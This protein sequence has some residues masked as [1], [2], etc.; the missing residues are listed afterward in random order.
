V[1]VLLVEDDDRVAGALSVA[2]GRHQMDVDRTGT[3]QQALEHLGTGNNHDV[4]LLDL[5]LPDLDGQVLCRQIREISDI[6]LIVV[7][8]RAGMNARLRSLDLGADDY[9]L[10]P[11][12][13]RELVARIHAVTRRAGSPTAAAASATSALGVAV[14]V[15]RRE[16]VV[17]GSAVA[18][19]RK[20][21]NLL[22]VLARQPGIV[23]TRAR[24][25]AEVWDTAW[26][27]NQRTLEVHV[28]S[29]RAKV[30]VPGI[31]ETVRGVGYRFPPA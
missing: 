30:G 24:I 27:G 14:D 5:G 15:E 28:A 9:V 20:E 26:T 1:R 3:A 29:V 8:A 19:T 11:F 21:F 17:G 18:L 13:P 25:L 2:L 31:I 16:V 10:K 22:A 4:V 7:T 12:D 6:P 23:V